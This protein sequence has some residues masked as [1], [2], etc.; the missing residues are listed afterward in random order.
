MTDDLFEGSLLNDLLSDLNA[1][2]DANASTSNAQN[3]DLFAILEQ[4]LTNTFTS[5]SSEPP[6]TVQNLDPAA[7]VVRQQTSTD[8]SSQDA[9]SDALSS[10]ALMQF[11]NMSLAADF[12]AADTAQ[13]QTVPVPPPGLAGGGAGG[14]GLSSILAG[15][16]FKEDEDYALD[17]ELVSG[18]LKLPRAIPPTGGAPTPST[19]VKPDTKVKDAQMANKTGVSLISEKAPPPPGVTMPTGPPPSGVM[20]PG[21]LPPAQLSHPTPV[22]R[23]IPPPPPQVGGANLFNNPNPGANPISADNVESGGMSFRDL[24]TTIHTMYRPLY[25]LDTYNDDY[26]HWSVVNRENHPMINPVWKNVKVL[27]KENEDKFIQSTKSRAEKFAEEK[28]TFGQSV[29]ANVKRPKALLNTPVLHRDKASEDTTGDGKVGSKYESELRRT[30]VQSWKARVSIDQGYSAFLSLIELRRLIQAN[31]GASRVSELLVDVKTQVDLLHSSLGFVSTAGG[32][33]EKSMK[34]DETRL[35]NTLSMRKGRVLCSRS[36]EEG[37]LPHSSACRILPVVARCIFSWPLPAEE[38][39]NRLLR[40]LTVLV[41]TPR[42]SVD[43]KTLCDCLGVFVEGGE[44][45]RQNLVTSTQ[46][47]TRMELLYAILSVGKAVC[48]DQASEESWRLKE[49]VIREALEGAQTK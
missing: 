21:P 38:G 14:G 18:E 34:V 36:I 37:V 48:V 25:S 6:S 32:D 3:D 49:Q 15:N 10:D 23:V 8:P 22:M 30:R 2:L 44:S 33:G 27:A 1:T 12:L 43:P 16:V 28:K 5:P 19:S 42:P 11:G 26:Y 39:E 45:G 7:H 35:A 46:S 41:R 40:S 13:K 47:Q 9:W 17:E 24:C 20:P 4:E 29:K 31:V